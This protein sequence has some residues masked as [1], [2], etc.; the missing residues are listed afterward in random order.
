MVIMMRAL[1]LDTLGV[2]EQLQHGSVRMSW[3]RVC[4]SVGFLAD[5]VFFVGRD[6]GEWSAVLKAF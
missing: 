4:F 1:T 5:N 6:S 2:A 3:G